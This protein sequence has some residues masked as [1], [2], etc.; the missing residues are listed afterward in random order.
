M[1][2]VASP[3]TPE[4]VK[5]K[6][7]DPAVRQKVV[8]ALEKT[9]K[10]RKAEAV[11]KATQL[12]LPIKGPG[13]ELKEFVAGNPVY[14][15]TCNANA[16]ISTGANLIR[17]VSPYN[18]DGTGETIGIWD[19][20]GV[21]TTH[22]ELYDRVTIKDDT[23][24]LSDHSTHVGGTI[25]AKGVQAPAMGMA[26]N[27]SIHSYDWNSDTGE[28]TSRGASYP[29]EPDKLYISSHSYGF[30]IGWYYD[31]GWLF[32]SVAWFGMYQEDSV[33]YDTLA[34]HAPYYLIC[35]AA[36][37]DRNE[38]PS[39]SEGDGIYKNGYD[40]IDPFGACKNILTVGA[41]NDA[42][43][44]ESRSVENATM[45]SFSSWGPSDDGRIKPDVVG[46]GVGLYSSLSSSDSAYGT[47]NGSSMATPN[48]SGSIVLLQDYI[49]NCFSGHV[50]RA[51]TVKAL[52]IHTADDLG[53][54]GP[55]Y[56]NG[57]GLVN[58]KAATDMVQAYKASQGNQKII[59]GRLTT[60]NPSAS[61]SITNNGGSAIRVTLCWT[62]P[63][64]TAKSANDDR[65]PA[66][67]N[68]LNLVIHGPD[69]NPHYP[70]IL[71]VF[72]PTNTAT[73]G[74]NRVDN[75]EQVYLAVPTNGI[76]TVTIN[77]DGTLT[78]GE[79]SYSLIMTGG[80][81]TGVMP[82]PALTSVTTNRLESVTHQSLELSGSG[83]MLGATVKL[84][85]TEQ[86]D[87]IATGVEVTPEYAVAHFDLTS[88]ATGWW[89]VMLIN[90]DNQ[91]TTLTNAV[92]IET[93]ALTI[94]TTSNLPAG[95]LGAPY[96]TTLE[97]SGGVPPYLWS[98][99]SNSLPEG[100]SISNNLGVIYGIPTTAT[101]Q[102]F[103]ISVTDDT[104]MAATNGFS[105]TIHPTLATALDT[106]ELI[107]QSTSWF[108][109]NIESHDMIDAAQSGVIGNNQSSELT[110]T[111]TGP[112][113]V[114]FWYRV[115]SETGWDFLN[116]YVG[117]ETTPR[118]S[119][120]G[121]SGWK[122][123]VL[124]IL[125]YTTQQLRFVYSKD[126]NTA[127]FQDCAWVDQVTLEPLAVTQISFDTQ[128]QGLVI[129]PINYAPGEI[130]SELPTPISHGSTFLGWFNGETQTTVESIVPSSPVLLVARWSD[131][132]SSDS[133]EQTTPFAIDGFNGWTVYDGDHSGTYYFTDVAFQNAG[134]PMAFIVF[135]PSVTVPS[136]EPYINFIPASGSQYFA[137]FSTT[138]PP[139]N[140]WLISTALNIPEGYVWTF[141]FKAQTLVSDWGLERF[142][143]LYSTSDNQIGSFTAL[144][145]EPYV[146]APIGWTAYTYELPAGTKYVAI[147]CVSY[148]A[149][150]FM[151]DA[152]SFKWVAPKVG[153]VSVPY[154]WLQGYNLGANDI[155]TL[156]ANG[157][158]VWQSYVAGLIP[159]NPASQFL[160]HIA[161]TNGHP[162]I[163]WTPD[164]SP[165]RTYTV[166]GKPNLTD[167]LWY[168]P[169]NTATRFFRVNVD[170]P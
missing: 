90:T 160:A 9:S 146:E 152:L 40:T 135:N 92:Y 149:F 101:N 163:T 103:N 151:L 166:E 22:Q 50:L 83:F 142:R 24:S 39:S 140:D 127:G 86:P 31:A 57:W 109:Q 42:V 112:V 73:T 79:Q 27:A 26:T 124:D 168:T 167:L 46:N 85:C 122:E 95:N 28:M 165:N 145:S 70:Y 143:V 121:D 16:A 1:L 107:W 20:A 99:V 80:A 153:N 115:S 84:T 53:R 87:I 52:V 131:G 102:F 15:I 75:V 81:D 147:N 6:Y 34:Y 158:P 111:V 108:G 164:M 8:T 89:N 104:G 94:I 14:F 49:S 11:E 169:T 29:G 36:G 3:S 60:V 129:A 96:S 97:A 41:V 10:Q 56:V 134:A 159:T 82:T 118:I 120:S 32:D 119:D 68:D 133:D 88:A 144:S 35:K 150:M 126:S 43:A 21:R 100:L 17:N 25:G 117:D 71:D 33:L 69:S 93:A 123:G 13:F 72:N 12:G 154:T 23:T 45:S 2:L 66:L 59:E 130:F 48:V 138:N 137:S 113:R 78:D 170:M 37:N 114:T 30:V 98:V 58:I 91:H 62:D 76:Y 128:K 64:G 74:T 162:T 116:I 38:N 77:Y 5:P 65:T 47:Y 61:Y 110:T 148:D 125:S 44:G 63:A 132:S 139:N 161:Y 136:L 106:T 157:Y 105:L 54:L 141:S 156:A 55:D 7:S 4:G 155:L 18:V 67:V 19:E 51:S